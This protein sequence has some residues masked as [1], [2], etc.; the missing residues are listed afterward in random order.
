[1]TQTTTGRFDDLGILGDFLA[2][3]SKKGFVTPTPIQQEV[4]P[5]ALAGTD[6]IG[7]AQTGTGKTL[8]FGIPMIQ[9]ICAN[10][11]KGIIIVPTRELAEQVEAELHKIGGEMGIKTAVLI[12]GAS[13]FKQ[14]KSL[15]NDPNLIIATPGR[16][17]DF[18]DR[19]LVNLNTISVV[20]LDEA[21]RMLDMGFLPS[22][23][24]VLKKIPAERQ[25]M[26]FSAT[27]PATI[28]RLANDFMRKPAKFEMAPQGTAAKNVSQEVYLVKET[29]KKN[30]LAHVLKEQKD[31][32][33]LVFVR[34]KFAAKRLVRNVQAMGH[35]AAEIHG[36]R[37]QAQRRAALDGFTK[38]RYRVLVATDVA[39][40]GIDVKDLS[41]VINYELPDSLEDYV[42]RIGRTGRAGRSGVALSLISPKQKYLV[43]RLEQ[44]VKK[45]MIIRPVP[46]D[47][48]DVSMLEEAPSN[49]RGSSRRSF[50][51]SRF[52]GG[53][54]RSSE[55]GGGRRRSFDGGAGSRSSR[56]SRGEGDFKRGDRGSFGKKREF[57][58]DGEF[59]KERPY[60]K[61]R[62]FGA[63]RDFNRDSRDAGPKRSYRR[64]GEYSKDRSFGAD[65]GPRRDRPTYGAD[66]G[67]RREGEFGTRREFGSP[68]HTRGA[69]GQFKKRRPSG[70]TEVWYTER[71]GQRPERSSYRGGNDRRSSGGFG[72]KKPFG[73][74]KGFGGKSRSFGSFKDRDDRR[75]KSTF[76]A[77]GRSGGARKKFGQKRTN[78]RFA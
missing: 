16:L 2:I 13:E 66:R 18:V 53:R 47:M 70:D 73:A 46:A 35:T 58:K 74:S 65:R 51:G 67:P 21:D 6:I 64:D 3:L 68:K 27:M 60:G 41:L 57:R 24:A 1:M 48:E 22:I 34:T 14:I 50:G 11:A 75:E 59:R 39:A 30:L 15:R 26:L 31:P 44:I 25:V 77:G 56:D 38:K 71:E 23:T 17:T 4:I 28:M 61:S 49:D 20:T 32:S 36:N 69:K 12:G 5:A 42:H 43:K 72:K 33:V 7:I 40:R 29:D 55:R 37:S 10:N 52:G 19:K 62:E 63:D 78:S 9:Q 8:A 45:S 54:G 76:A